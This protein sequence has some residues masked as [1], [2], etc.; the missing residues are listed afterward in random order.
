MCGQ[1]RPA[2]VTRGKAGGVQ[3]GNL[4]RPQIKNKKNNPEIKNNGTAESNRQQNTP[5]GLVSDGWKT[6]VYRHNN[7][8]GKND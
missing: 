4:L 6:W 7:I 2:R 5:R 1:H 3:M 8:A